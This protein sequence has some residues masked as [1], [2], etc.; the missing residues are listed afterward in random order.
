MKKVIESRVRSEEE[1]VERGK[2]VNGEKE[3]KEQ[4]KKDDGSLHTLSG[5]E[6]FLVYFGC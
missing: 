2:G 3:E 1:T 4:P 6:S 5:V